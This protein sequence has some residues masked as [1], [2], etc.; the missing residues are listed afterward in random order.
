LSSPGARGIEAEPE[1]TKAI[2]KN[3]QLSVQVSPNPSAYYFNL[4][5]KGSDASPVSVSVVDVA[6][7][8][9]K[10]LKTTAN[11]SSR[12]GDDLTAGTYFVEVIQG[13]EKKVL[14]IIKL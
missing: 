1:F 2:E 12:F 10:R 9:V 7:R 6:G 3:E 5:V 14:K 8:K 13:T 4:T 11:T